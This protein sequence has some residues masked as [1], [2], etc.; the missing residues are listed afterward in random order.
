MGGLTRLGLMLATSVAGWGIGAAIAAPHAAA[1]PISPGTNTCAPDS[2]T[3]SPSATWVSGTSGTI[4][5]CPGTPC[6]TAD[7]IEN[8]YRENG[9]TAVCN[10]SGCLTWV[11]QI[12]ARQ[13]QQSA[14]IIQRITVGNFKGFHTDIGVE[15]NTPPPG[16][17]PFT[18]TGTNLPNNVERD[19]TGS[20][21][22][23]DFNAG[24][25]DIGPGMGSTLLEIE[26]DAKIV[27]PGTI[28]IQNATAGSQPALGPA[29]PDAMWVP[30]LGAIG[31]AAAGAVALRRRKKARR[32][33]AGE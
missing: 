17:P 13:V 12:S 25:N 19:S 16:N 27:I 4:S 1:C 26:T 32:A 22:A 3:V 23:W 20:V 6:F 11:V 7:W 9:N 14:D 30:A 18:G 15:T 24:P 31:G 21:L 29:L 33:V 10:F 5:T 2:L 28:S 8:V